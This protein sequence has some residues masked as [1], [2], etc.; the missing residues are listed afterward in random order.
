MHNTEIY[1]HLGQY[2]HFRFFEAERKQHP[3]LTTHEMIAAHI[4]QSHS[5]EY[6]AAMLKK[7]DLPN[8]Q[9]IA[10]PTQPPK[11]APTALDRAIERLLTKPSP[12]ATAA[13]LD[14]VL[15]Q[16]EVR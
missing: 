6:V 13:A 9:Q 12:E 4:R 1:S 3:E 8:E 14:R 7:P 16:L 11:P 2:G 5:D 15:D 10:A